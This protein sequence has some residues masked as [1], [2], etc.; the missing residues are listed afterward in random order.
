[1]ERYIPNL[2]LLFYQGLIFYNK[3]MK[4]PADQSYKNVQIL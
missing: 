3:T 4:N 1:M 2:K